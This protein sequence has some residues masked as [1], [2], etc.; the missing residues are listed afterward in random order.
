MYCFLSFPGKTEMAEAWT[1][2]QNVAL[3]NEMKYIFTFHKEAALL[4]CHINIK[5]LC[6]QRIEEQR[7]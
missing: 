1:V 7:L 2:T 6:L 3:L 5:M 4:K